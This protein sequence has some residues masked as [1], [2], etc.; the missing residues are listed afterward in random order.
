MKQVKVLGSGCGNGRRTAQLIE[1]VVA[2]QGVA[3]A[4]TKVEDVSEIAA[5]GVMSTP[6]VVLDGQVAHAGG[7]PDR[8]L[9]EQWL[10]NK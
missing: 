9:V 8:R 7:V 5:H 1:T 6:G 3:I 2:D 10:G 4:L